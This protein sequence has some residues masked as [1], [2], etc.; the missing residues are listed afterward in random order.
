[1]RS[2]TSTASSSV[3]PPTGNQSASR[4]G[5][6]RSRSRSS[7]PEPSLIAMASRPEVE[8]RW[9]ARI[10]RQ[11]ASGAGADV[12]DDRRSRDQP[13][14][15]GTR[16]PDAAALARSSWLSISTQS[17]SPIGCTSTAEAAV[18]QLLVAVL[19][20][21]LRVALEGRF[22]RVGQVGGGLAAR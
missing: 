4:A 14:Q 12:D 1:M 13:S 15:Y 21:Q 18:D 17:T 22:Q 5:T 16:S 7:L 6:A 9:S 8:M 10:A 19:V 11:L 3:P 2:A 20:V